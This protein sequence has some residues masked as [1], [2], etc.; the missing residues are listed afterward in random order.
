[1]ISTTHANTRA[2]QRGIPRL[3]TNWLLDYGDELH[4]G[5]GAVVRYFSRRSLRRLEREWGSMA[6][7]RFSEFLRCYLVES[8]GDGTIITIGKRHRGRHLNRR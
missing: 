4:D 2:Q 8:G 5:H 6:L 3:V 7:R 1:M